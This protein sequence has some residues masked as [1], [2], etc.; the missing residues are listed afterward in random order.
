MQPSQTTPANSSPFKSWL[1]ENEPYF[2]AL[3]VGFIVVFGGFISYLQLGISEKQTK[4]AEQSLK[5]S[6]AELKLIELQTDLQRMD[7][8]PYFTFSHTG[9]IPN[10]YPSTFFVRTKGD[11]E[12]R[13]LDGTAKLFLVVKSPKGTRRLLLDHFYDRNFA[14]PKDGMVSFSNSV[15][16]I[17][18]R[19]FGCEIAN[20]GKFY[21]C[22]HANDPG[23]YPMPFTIYN[24][25]EVSYVG[26]DSR[27]VTQRFVMNFPDESPTPVQ[28]QPKYDATFDVQKYRKSEHGYEFDAMFD[29]FRE[30]LKRESGS[31][32][33]LPRAQKPHKAGPF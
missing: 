8:Q 10:A 15:D 11:G 26:E 29:D 32:I 6:E 9:V 30:F 7:H 23:R 4:V 3:E 1:T 18:P 12:V 5:V 24:F 2:R 14:S 13:G 20:Y 27:K 22:G 21:L 17:Y 19:F 16:F 25:V 33:D 31:A 28:E